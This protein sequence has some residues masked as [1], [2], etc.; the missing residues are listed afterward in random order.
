MSCRV[1]ARGIG[2]VLINLIRGYAKQA[3]VRLQAGFVET[4][5][6]RM[7]YMTYKFSRFVEISREGS[8]LTLENDLHDVN[9]PPSYL[10]LDISNLALPVSVP[11]GQAVT[12]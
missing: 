6:N 8:L 10:E 12:L 11:L 5:R 3:G 2:N 1:M 7:M 4:D 9:P